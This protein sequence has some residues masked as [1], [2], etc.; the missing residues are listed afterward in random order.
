MDL[1]YISKPLFILF[2]LFLVAWQVFLYFLKKKTTLSSLAEI[3]LSGV[4]VV[5]HAVA[6]TVILLGGG[7]LS[8]ALVLVL[9]SGAVSLALSPKQAKEEE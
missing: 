4:G 7:T 9:L 1:I 2:P 6:I 8:D 5:G 3:I